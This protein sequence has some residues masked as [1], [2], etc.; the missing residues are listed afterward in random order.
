MVEK[1]QQRRRRRAPASLAILVGVLAVV[2]SG[3][4]GKSA[5]QKANEAYASGVCTAIG[6]WETQVKNIVGSISV[7]NLSKSGLQSKVTQIESATKTLVTDIKAVPPP[8][9][10][11]GQAAKTQID[12][13]DT[14]VT[15]TVN[16]AKSAVAQIPSDASATALATALAPLA[17]QFASL[18]T[19]A[20]A[21]V[22]AIETAGSSL[23]DAFKSADSC[24]NLK[25]SN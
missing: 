25:S 22:T 20:Q 23:A 3:C 16:S 12:Q 18:A 11:D 15:S 21:T 8:N 13:L 5:D 9:T 4:G 19:T 17:P 10:S 14:E 24:K 1:Q 6:S 2:L 7:T